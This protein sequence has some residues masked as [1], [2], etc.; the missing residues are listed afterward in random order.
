MAVS[1]IG[2][3]V[4]KAFVIPLIVNVYFSVTLEPWLFILRNGPCHPITLYA[5]TY[6]KTSQYCLAYYTTIHPEAV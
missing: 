2:M 6:G 5:I 1:V 4:I 3:S